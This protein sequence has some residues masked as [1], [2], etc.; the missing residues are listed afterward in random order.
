M[1]KAEKK[2]LKKLGKE[3]VQ[4]RSDELHAQLASTNP[5]PFASDEYLRNEIAIREKE[6][7]LRK[8]QRAYSQQEILA[9]FVVRPLGFDLSAT[10]PGSDDNY[11]ECREC[12]DFIPTVLAR[13]L[14]CGCG[15]V[16]ITQAG[17]VVRDEG[18]LRLVRLL[19]KA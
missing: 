15:N 6:R 2:R 18:C 8:E 19:G 17:F 4:R 7:Q 11:W 3:L 5:A 16:R 1:D 10:Y 13:V 12:G 14:Q 9:N